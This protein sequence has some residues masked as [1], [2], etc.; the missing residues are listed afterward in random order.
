MKGVDIDKTVKPIRDR[1]REINT[2]ESIRMLRR[3]VS[4]SRFPAVT[5]WEIKIQTLLEWEIQQ[6]I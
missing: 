3:R 1:M 5:H 6:M 4:S 2:M